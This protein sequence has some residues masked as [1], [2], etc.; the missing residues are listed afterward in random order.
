MRFKLMGGLRTHILPY[1]SSSIVCIVYIVYS[2]VPKAV[3]ETWLGLHILVSS[4][5]AVKFA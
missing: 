2:S 5:P 4:L 3:F 1:C